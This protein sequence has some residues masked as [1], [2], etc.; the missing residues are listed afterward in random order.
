M[1][2]D[3]FISS[4][5]YDG[6]AA[7]VDKSRRSKNSGKTLERLVLSAALPHLR[8]IKI[9]KTAYRLLRTIIMP[10]LIRTIRR[11]ILPACSVLQRRIVK[12]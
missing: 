4:I 9:L 10:L 1:K 11:K 6:A 2:K 8:S 3:D 5:G 12:K 7:V